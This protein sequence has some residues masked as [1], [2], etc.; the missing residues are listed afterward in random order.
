MGAPPTLGN[1][2]LVVEDVRVAEKHVRERGH[3]CDRL[4]HSEALSE[5]HEITE[6]LRNGEY[7]ALYINTAA[8]LHIKHQKAR[9]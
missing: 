4:T 9:R 3:E 5:N 1:R 8:E 2:G 6:K 7:Y